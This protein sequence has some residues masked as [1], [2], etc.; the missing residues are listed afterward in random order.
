MFFFGFISLFLC[1]SSSKSSVICPILKSGSYQFSITGEY[2]LNVE[3]Q[4]SFQNN[5][6]EDLLSNRTCKLELNF[7]PNNHLEGSVIKFIV[8]ADNFN[9]NNL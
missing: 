2:D 3:G 1:S 7:V 6:E 9:E 8:D 5:V 4:T